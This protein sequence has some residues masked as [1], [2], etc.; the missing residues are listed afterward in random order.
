MRWSAGI[1]T[2]SAMLALTVMITVRGE[3]R[4]KTAS[5]VPLMP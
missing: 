1:T 2:T 3:Y 5:V 4:K